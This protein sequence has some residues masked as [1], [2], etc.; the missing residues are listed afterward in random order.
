[1]SSPDR[2]PA[3]PTAMGA[4]LLDALCCPRCAGRLE[5]STEGSSCQGCGRR[6]PLVDSLP[7]LVDDPDL[8]RA[9]WHRQVDG[10][11]R[12]IERRVA[13]IHQEAESVGLIPRTRQRLLRIAAAFLE[14]RRTITSLCQVLHSD[15]SDPLLA[16]AL[17]G[18]PE[19]PKEMPILRCYNG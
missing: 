2:T 4:S 5:P 19:D 10:Y 7:C 14:Q 11:A 12:S 6:Y 8:W 1:M 15:G 17:R 9:A 3:P 13:D 16:A 18:P